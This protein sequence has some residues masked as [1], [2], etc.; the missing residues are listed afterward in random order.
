MFGTISQGF[1]DN[2]VLPNNPS[3][4]AA[5]GMIAAG[6]GGGGWEF[7][8][9]TADPGAVAGALQEFN[10][11]FTGVFFGL[12]TPFDK[13]QNQALTSNTLSVSLP[14]VNTLNDGVLVAQSFGNV[15]FFA[16]ATP[17]VDGSN[18]TIHNF[19]NETAAPATSAANWIYLPYEAENLVAGRVADDGSVLAS[20]GVGTGAGQFTLTKDGTGAYLLTIAGK[21]PADGTLLL[22]PEATGGVEDNLL[23]YEAAGNSFRIIGVDQVTADERQLSAILPAPEDTNFTF[24][25]IDYDAPPT[26]EPGNFLEADFDEDGDVDSTD[27]TAWRNGFGT[28]ATKAA[29][30]ADADSDVDGNDFLT[31]QRQLGASPPATAAAGAVPEPNAAA[32]ALVAAAAVL[33]AR[34]RSG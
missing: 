31:W 11:N 15:D 8:T 27:L 1:R 16:V 30:D 12:D 2:T 34:R 21:T 32:L 18:W 17:A 9:H 26:L 24:A 14:G 33:S 13:A 4:Q 7:A 29:G 3:G 6:D 10:V 5:Y 25:F 20:T 23:V 28:G 19:N 22:T